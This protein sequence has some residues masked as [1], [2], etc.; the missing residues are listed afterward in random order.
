[1]SYEVNMMS[2]AALKA[3]QAQIN[4]E[5]AQRY[6]AVADSLDVDLDSSIRPACFV[7]KVSLARAA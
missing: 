2:D 6:A 1:M 7:D 5:L 3:L 4:Q